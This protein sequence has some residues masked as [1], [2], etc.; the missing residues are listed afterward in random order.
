MMG[1][2]RAFED[3][4]DAEGVFDALFEESAATNSSMDDGHPRAAEVASDA[5]DDLLAAADASP[6][7]NDA[8]REALAGAQ[9]RMGEERRAEMEKI[10]EEVA[11]IMQRVRAERAMNA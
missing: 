2:A 6:Y 7:F 4:A 9:K 11:V 5:P 10:D 1:R 3:G 8:F